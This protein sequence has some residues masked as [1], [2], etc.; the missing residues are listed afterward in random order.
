MGW[1]DYSAP[2]LS[3]QQTITYPLFSTDHQMIE[4]TGKNM[5]RNH[6]LVAVGTIKEVVGI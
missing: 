5:S 1:E 4:I 3:S 2:T 6:L